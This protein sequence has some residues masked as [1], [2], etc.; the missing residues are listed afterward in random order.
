MKTNDEGFKL[1][2]T[3][4]GLRLQVYKCPANVWTIG[5]GHTG[6]VVKGQIID[7][8]TAEQLLKKDLEKFE[9]EV[10]RLVTVSLNSNQFSALVSFTYNVGPSA[11]AKSTLLRFL[12]KS[13]YIETALQFGRW[14]RGG[15][16]ILPGLVRR[17]EAEKNLFIKSV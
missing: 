6:N 3:F 9:A 10:K 4:E 8:V 11:F 15:G 5:Y 12:N 17:R 2:K 7:I 16:V 1:I 14:T 13:K